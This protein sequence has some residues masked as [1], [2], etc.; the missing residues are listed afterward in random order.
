VCKLFVMVDNVCKIAKR[1]NKI[2]P[3]PKGKT[4]VGIY[5]NL[6]KMLVEIASKKKMNEA[7][8]KG[9]LSNLNQL[10]EFKYGSMYAL[11]TM[12][13]MMQVYEAFSVY[14]DVHPELSWSHYLELAKIDKDAKRKFYKE[15]AVAG[16]WSVNLLKRQIKSKF[17]ERTGS[18]NG[19]D[20]LKEKYVLEF[21]QKPS[22]ALKNEYELESQ[23]LDKLQSLL[24]E[25]GNGYSFVARQKRITSPNGMVFYIDLVFYHFIRKCFVLIDLKTTP[26]THENLGQMDMYIRLWD[27][28]QKGETDNPTLGIVLCPKINPDFL[29][30]SMLK[31]S[32]QLFAAPYQLAFPEA[33]ELISEF[34][35]EALFSQ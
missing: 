35:I 31:G 19:F 26:M 13:Q 6:G 18:P 15:E 27:T 22:G 25:L 23:L 34:N 7:E 1:I 5:W 32:D 11:K 9:M 14:E 3:N 17:F 16:N 12:Q 33:D 30:Y 28:F 21:A 29:E 24:E 20:I 8:R 4:K 10:L 2:A